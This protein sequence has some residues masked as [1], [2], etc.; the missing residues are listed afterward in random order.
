MVFVIVILC[1]LSYINHMFTWK[2]RNWIQ[3]GTSVGK[4]LADKPCDLRLIPRNHMVEGH[5]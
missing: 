2:N 4:V 3:R 1:V 5:T